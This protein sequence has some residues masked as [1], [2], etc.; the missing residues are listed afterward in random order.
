[1]FIATAAFGSPGA[2]ENHDISVS[3]D[4]GTGGG[5]LYLQLLHVRSCVL[6]KCSKV[7]SLMTRAASELDRFRLRMFSKKETLLL[8]GTIN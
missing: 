5:G 6:A 7:T 2:E 1:M 3:T 8:S 4:I